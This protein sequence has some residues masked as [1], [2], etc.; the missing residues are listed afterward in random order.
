MMAN[1]DLGSMIVR[2]GLDGTDFDKGAKNLN[3]RMKLAQSELKASASSFDNFGKSIDGLKA[4]QDGLSKIYDLQGRKVKQLRQQYDDLVKTQGANSEAALKVGKSLNYEISSYNKLGKQLD[5]VKGE[6]NDL[7]DELNY[8]ASGWKKAEKSI[9]SFADRA[10]NAGQTMQSVGQT[11]TLGVSAPLAALGAVAIKSAADIQK[12]QGKIQASLGITADEAK[13]LNESA[14]EIWKDGFGTDM[15]EASEGITLVRQNL[16]KITGKELE[17]VTRQAFILRDTFGYEIPESTRAAKALIDNF[18]VEGSRAMDYITVAAQKGGDYSKELLDTISEYSV[19][20]KT[21]G[22]DIDDMFNILLQGAQKGSWS[23]DKTADSIKEMSIRMVDGSKTTANGLKM[24]GLNADDMSKKFAEGGESAQSA[25]MATVAAIASMEDPL[26][27]QQAGVSIFGTQWEDVQK[28]VI[29]ALDPTIDML[30]DVTGATDK[31]G[32]ALKDNFSDRATQQLRELGAAL[33]P[34]G[35]ILLDVVE[36]ALDSASDHLKTFTEW[37]EG[38]SPTGKNTVVALLGIAAVLPPLLAGFGFVAQGVGAVT[39]SLS[40]GVGAFGK[41]VIAAKATDAVLDELGDSADK[42]SKKVKGANDSYDKTGKGLSKLK[43]GAGLAAGSL[44]SVGSGAGLLSGSLGLL[45]NPI[46]GIIAAIGGT[47]TAGTLLYKNW[48]KIQESSTLFKASLVTLLPGLYSIVSGIKGVQSISLETIP[49]IENFGE[50]VSE[51]TTKA[52]LGYK[53]LNDEATTELNELMW[54]GQIIT[55]QMSDTITGIFGKMG[56]QISTSLKSDYDKSYGFMSEYFS[57]SKA[58]SETEEATILGNTQAR[59]NRQ[60]ET[61]Q[62]QEAKIKEIMDLASKEKRTLTQEEKNQINQIQQNMMTTAVQTMSKSEVEQKVILER[63]KNESANI[64]AQQ[65]ADTV[66]NSL[67]A[68]NGAVKE[69][70]DK[71][72]K[73]IAAIIRERD[74]TGSISAEQANKLIAEAD[75]QRKESIKKAEEMHL[76]V[77]NQAKLQAEGHIGQVD[78]TTGKVKSKWQLMVEY[79]AQYVND[80]SDSINW[81]LDKLNVDF[82][83][84]KWTPKTVSSGSSKPRRATGNMEQYAKGTSSTGHPY[85][86]LAIVS[87]RG[88]ELIHEPGIG[89]YLSGS[90]GPEMRYLRKGTSVLPNHHTEK[91]LKSYGFPGYENGV[92]SFFDWALKGPKFLLGKTMDRFGVSSF[93]SIG[94]VFDKVGGGIVSTIKNYG[95][96]FLKGKLENLLSFGS[97]FVGGG[98]EVARKA[99]SMALS[100]LGKSQAFLP[101][102]MQVAKHESGF[103]PRAVNNWDINAQRGDP[104]VGL[105]QIINSTFQRWKYPG[106]NDRTNPL[107]SALAAIRYLDGRYGGIQNHPGLLSMS[108]GG[109]YRP[110]ARGGEIN[111]KQMALL[112]E[113]GWKEWVLTSEPQYRQRNLSMW[114]E[115]GQALGVPSIPNVGALNQGN[116]GNQNGISLQ[117]S[118]LFETITNFFKNP[119]EL[120]IDLTA[121]LDG[122]EISKRT[123]KYDM[124]NIERENDYM[125]SVKG[126]V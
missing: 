81:I 112:G 27:Q 63:L 20:F 92:G 101:G 42:S 32:K 120:K 46:T 29:G 13:E 111:Y 70:N 103:N 86:G 109:G 116:F 78:W 121:E 72:D 97:D 115:A 31:A 113:N 21:A 59:Y 107:H 6:L 87:E 10:S 117:F 60:V 76:G 30:G 104:S 25:F 114:A 33:Q 43:G 39:K 9:A 35:D 118:K 74:E 125:K 100:M 85:D 90:N 82:N 71:Y 73:T 47:V 105:F 54:S 108:R 24:I 79:A 77:V 41:Y 123:F 38:L 5:T 102:L 2:V 28:N 95:E 53:K 119:I 17:D 110:Y 75:R 3:A 93:P 45:M 50:K 18:G 58:L 124:Q 7:T 64:T 69:A 96:N 26:K 36:P 62:M 126:D 44:V 15:S 88:R 56:D 37:M 51:S 91:L 14:K 89:T 67:K 84:P 48:E 22:M 40:V 80:V 65:A 8:Q 83:I 66:A 99:I 23:L 12:S 1:E 61:V 11:L 122:H 49:K 98:A 55:Q 68:K 34:L 16:Q 57:K 52:V 19:Q 106:M 94:G 4:K